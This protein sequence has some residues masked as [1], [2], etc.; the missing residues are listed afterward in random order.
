MGGLLRIAKNRAE[1]LGPKQTPFPIGQW[2]GEIDEVRVKDLPDFAE[3]ENSGFTSTAGEIISI[4]LGNN[5]P[6][7]PNSTEEVGGRKLFIDIVTRDGDYEIYDEVPE[8]AWRIRQSQEIAAN[9]AF[10]LGHVE[11]VDGNWEIG[12]GFFDALR[13]G[14]LN[15]ARVGFKLYHRKTKSEKRPLVEQVEEF[16][17]AS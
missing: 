3:K 1:S 7:D 10:A 14:Q 11:E 8:S 9:L 6:A 15:G 12:D 13:D 17:A 4:Q 5:K 16:F 2:V